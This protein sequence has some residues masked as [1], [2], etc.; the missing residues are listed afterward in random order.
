MSG[1]VC[2]LRHGLRADDG[3]WISE[4]RYPHWKPCLLPIILSDKKVRILDER[5]AYHSI[6]GHICKPERSEELAV[7][8]V[9]VQT[10]NERLAVGQIR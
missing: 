9:H 7:E 6:R 1:V 2:S 3:V 5:G 10:F 4:L 8:I